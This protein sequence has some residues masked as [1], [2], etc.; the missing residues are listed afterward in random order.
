VTTPSLQTVTV[1]YFA[2]LREQAGCSQEVVQTSAHTV[3]DLYREAQTRHGLALPPERIGVAV[4]DTFST[5]DHVIEANDT[6]AL[7]P[8]VCGG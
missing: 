7:M 3:L 4:N 1:L 5:L 8:P 2:V 6:V